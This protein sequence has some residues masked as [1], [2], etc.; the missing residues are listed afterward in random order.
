MAYKIISK[1]QDLAKKWRYWIDNGDG[2]VQML[3]FDE[4]IDDDTVILNAEEITQKK[5]KQKSLKE[6][7]WRERTK[8]D[9]GIDY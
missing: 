7:D 2:N 9:R 1:E 4:E 5:R 3:K 8:Q 6:A